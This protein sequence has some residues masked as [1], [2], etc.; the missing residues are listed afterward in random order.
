[1]APYNCCSICIKKCVCVTCENKSCPSPSY[2][3]ENCNTSNKT[4]GT[5]ECDNYIDW[6]SRTRGYKNGRWNNSMK[7]GV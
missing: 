6:I 1:M 3:N 7:N 4:P 5:D 2:I